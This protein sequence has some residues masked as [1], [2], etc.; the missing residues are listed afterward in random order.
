MISVNI[1]TRNRSKL[2]KKAINSALKQSYDNFEIIIIDDDSS[3]DTKE[4]VCSFNDSRIKYFKTN[5][6]P[7]LNIARNLAISKSKGEYIAILDDD[8]E[9]IDI[10]KLQ[11]QLDFLESHKN[12]SIIG[13]GAKC[14]DEN[15]KFLFKYLKPETDLR[16]KNT[17][18]ASSPFIHSSVLF[19]KSFAKKVNFYDSNNI[20]T[21]LSQDYNLFLKLGTISKLY[22]LPEYS[23]KYLI[24]SKSHGH[25]NIRKQLSTTIKLANKYKNYYPK[26][27]YYNLLKNYIKYIYFGYVKFKN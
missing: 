20:N 10:N 17:I 15:N 7:A 24:S 5:K 13:T 3:D 6:Q 23:I 4:V 27:K 1:I 25:Q 8:D 14:V 11:K 21:N 9:W 12:Y 2:L 18:L 22:N 16:I 19:K 26:N